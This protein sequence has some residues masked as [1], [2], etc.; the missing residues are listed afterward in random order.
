MMSSLLKG[1][2]VV[3]GG[4]GQQILVDL[5]QVHDGL[6]S[7]VLDSGARGAP[8]VLGVEGAGLEL[9]LTSI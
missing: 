4:G 8:L 5:A 6:A 1:R 9:A 2:V 7:Y 3:E